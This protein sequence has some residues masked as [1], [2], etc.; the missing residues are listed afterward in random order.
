[1]QIWIEIFILMKKQVYGN[2]EN[3]NLSA[4]LGI[5][6]DEDGFFENS[7]KLNRTST[8]KDGVFIAG[9]AHGPK[10]IGASI[11]H[12]GQAVSGVRKY[13]GGAI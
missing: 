12:A 13:L 4:Q 1:M 9:T 3:Q 7:D 6:L 11:A 2:P 8:S 10:N 5:F